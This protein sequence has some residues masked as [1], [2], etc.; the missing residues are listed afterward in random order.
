MDLQNPVRKNRFLIVNIQKV[1]FIKNHKI[2]TALTLTGAKG[3]PR[4]GYAG[5]YKENL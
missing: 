3:R 5:R 2:T 4:S 1:S